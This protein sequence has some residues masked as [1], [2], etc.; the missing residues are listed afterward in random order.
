MSV[1]A[2][3]RRWSAFTLVELLVV[4]AIIALLIAILLPMLQKAKLAAQRTACMSNT[5]QLTIAYRMYAEDNHGYMPM[6][7]PDNI[8][9]PQNQFVPW[10]LGAQAYG[11]LYGNTDLAIQKGCLFQ[12]LKNKG[13]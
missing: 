1:H 2:V 11:A 4:I 8:P 12:Y 6:G 9:S 13:V 5:R 3:K 10:F 7:W